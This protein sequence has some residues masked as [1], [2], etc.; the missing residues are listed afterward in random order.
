[1]M[2]MVLMMMSGVNGANHL[3]MSVGGVYNFS[4]LADP[5]ASQQTRYSSL[6]SFFSLFAPL[7]TLLKVRYYSYSLLLLPL[8]SPLSPLPSPLSPLP[9]PLSHL[10]SP[11][12]HLSSLLSLLLP[13]YSKLLSLSPSLLLISSSLLFSSS[14]LLPSSSPLSSSLLIFSSG[15]LAER[16]HI[17]MRMGCR[18]PT[19]IGPSGTSQQSLI[20]Q[21]GRREGRGCGRG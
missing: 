4:S 2:M 17:A 14:S 8:P 1:M 3:D 12:S 10:L 7:F 15:L 11:I 6:L 18:R 9:S 20:R 5:V 13:R 21:V 19:T 16:V